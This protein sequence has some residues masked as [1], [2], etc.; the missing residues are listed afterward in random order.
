MDLRRGAWG[1]LPRR[2]GTPPRA[3]LRRRADDHGGGQ[4][5]LLLPPAALLVRLVAGP[6]AGRLRLRDQGW[7]V[8]Q[9][10]E[11]D[12]RGRDTAGDL[13]RL[14]TLGPRPQAGTGA[15]AAAREPAV[16]RGAAGGL[17]RPPPPH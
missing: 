11:E 13:L 10:H 5:L 14:G 7:P 9:P 15:V 3:R 8:H 12:T 17:L 1:L 6:D 16:R 4:R 2:T